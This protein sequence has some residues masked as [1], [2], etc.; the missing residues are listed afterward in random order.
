M[1][2]PLTHFHSTRL[3]PHFLLQTPAYNLQSHPYICMYLYKYFIS[4]AKQ[5]C[6]WECSGNC[7]R[8]RFEA[9]LNAS[10]YALKCKQFS[11]RF[12]CKSGGE[13]KHFRIVRQVNKQQWLQLH[14]MLIQQ[15]KQQCCVYSKIGESLFR[16]K[17][18]MPVC[19]VC[20]HLLLLTNTHFILL[21]CM[22]ECV[23][24]YVHRYIWLPNTIQAIKFTFYN[25]NKFGA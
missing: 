12:D 9:K 5:L 13:R 19:R 22:C 16:L 7:L 3:W 6:H 17:P 23:C 2:F 25:N 10:N 1:Y 18:Y 21:T 11:L 4:P 20:L 14:S 24:V 8:S 15:Q